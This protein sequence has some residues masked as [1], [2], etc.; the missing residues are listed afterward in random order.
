PKV[1][2]DNGFVAGT[3]SDSNATYYGLNDTSLLAARYSPATG[4]TIGLGKFACAEN[5]SVATVISPDGN[6]VWGG[7]GTQLNALGL[8]L[9]RPFRWTVASG[10]VQMP[11]IPGDSNLTTFTGLNCATADGSMVL[12]GSGNTGNFRWTAWPTGG[13]PFQY[14][15][16][17][18]DVVG[19]IF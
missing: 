12:G 19:Q 16:Q 6:T 4:E 15:D 11:I 7:S 5:Y 18:H 1:V 14:P 2:S 8:F 9:T 10:M 3:A 17:M 13:T